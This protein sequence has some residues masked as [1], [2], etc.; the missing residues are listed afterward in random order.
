MKKILTILI[1]A[2]LCFSCVAY[3][4]PQAS[5]AS[6]DKVNQAGAVLNMMGAIEGDGGSSLGLDDTLTRAQFCK[7]AVVV[8]GLS[9]K[10]SQYASYTIFPDVLSSDWEAGYVNVAVRYAGIMSGYANG[11]FQPDETITYGQVITVLVRMLGYTDDEVG[12]N[13]PYGHIEKAEEIGL[14]DGVSLS[15]NDVITKGEMAVLFMNMLGIE[16][17]GSTQTYI[18]SLSGTTVVS[19]VFLVSANA[20][21]DGGVSGAVEIAGSTSAAYLP[22]N[23]VPDELLGEFGSLVL[24]SAGKAL[25]F[26]PSSSGQTVISTIESVESGYIL[27]TNGLKITMTA[28]PV[29]YLDGEAASYSSAWINLSS[30]M[31]ISAYYT[32][33]GTVSCVLVSSA[34]SFAESIIVVTGDSYSLP[35][36]A[37]VY[38]NGEEAS[39]SDIIKYDVIE[40]DKDYNVYTVTRK[41]VTGLYESASPN[42]ALPETIQ[43]LG[44]EF[45]LLDSAVTSAMTYDIGDQ[46]MLLLTSDNKVAD[47]VSYYKTNINYGVVQSITSSSA[48]VELING[49]SI[50]GSIDEDNSEFIAGQLVAVHSSQIGYLYLSSITEESYTTYLN[51]ENETLGG[52]SLASS[53]KIFDSAGDTVVEISLSDISESIVSGSNILFADYDWSGDVELLVLDDVTGDAYSYGFIVNGSESQS[54]GGLTA[55]NPTTS[56]TNSNGTTEAVLGSTG[57]YNGYIAGIAVTGDGRL[58]D[59]VTLSSITDIDNTN[60]QES[61]DGKIYVEIDNGLLQVSD[62]VQVYMDNTSSWT[63]L[64]TVRAVCDNM[65][66]Y[67]DRTLETGGK[68]R[69]IIAN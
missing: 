29:F 35:A 61:S 36:G 44:T 41:H 7:I 18:E 54:S 58:A 66:I 33:G 3:V 51:V 11:L 13:W 40:Y 1:A 55:T 24:N 47:V 27:C 21:T 68:I 37:S 19:N 43:V 16:V 9:N 46:V 34:S 23:E 38:I 39:A 45:E 65:T 63:T 28:S 49:I 52:R 10:V 50:S 30:G 60:F 12:A 48:V 69:V 64:D 14:T 59:Y 17:N 53:V 5:A 8:M 56:I 6:Q 20:E 4:T 32:E 26:I 15:A 57:L 31:R 22:V 62:D 67:Y 25:T 42:V 2:A